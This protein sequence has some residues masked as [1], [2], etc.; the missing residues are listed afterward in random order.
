MQQSAPASS[1]MVIDRRERSR[2]HAPPARQA[3]GHRSAHKGAMRSAHKSW[4]YCTRVRP[5]LTGLSWRAGRART[6]STR[7]RPRCTP[8]G[9][10]PSPAYPGAGPNPI[11]CWP[12]ADP[13]RA[14]HRQ[15]AQLFTFL[16]STVA[17][18]RPWGAYSAGCAR[19][20][21]QPAAPGGDHRLPCAVGGAR[22]PHPDLRRPAHLCRHA[23]ARAHARGH[24]GLPRQ[25]CGAA[26]TP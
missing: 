20:P 25:R 15:H 7:R 22:G 10:S 8:R 5:P 24:G 21:A 11:P 26:A 18:W 6:S 4:L 3:P 12:R 19:A 23:A 13:A 16:V 9:A 2:L 17:P 1:R 14:Q